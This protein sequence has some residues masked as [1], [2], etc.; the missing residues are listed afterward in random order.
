MAP[1]RTSPSTP[2]PITRATY[3]DG[4]FLERKGKSTKISDKERH[5]IWGE[6]PDPG[7]RAQSYA[8]D[9]A[10][11]AAGFQRGVEDMVGW[12]ECRFV[13]SAEFLPFEGRRHGSR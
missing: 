12:T 3:K 4:D 2:C 10:E 6:R 5:V 13:P 11:R 1:P 7:D 8:F 9:S